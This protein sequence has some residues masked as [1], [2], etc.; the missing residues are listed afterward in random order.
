L[1]HFFAK[2]MRAA[3]KLHIQINEK[4]IGVSWV[5]ICLFLLH[6]ADMHS[7]YL[8]RQRG[9]LAGWLAGWLYDTPRYCINIL[10]FSTIW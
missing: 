9:W 2:S 3:V 6:D 7:A 4:C 10:F 5:Y 8:L 1:S